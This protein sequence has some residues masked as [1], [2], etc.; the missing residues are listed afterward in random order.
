MVGATEKHSV[1]LRSTA[2]LRRGGLSSKLCEGRSMVPTLNEFGDVV[3]LENVDA[4]RAS[5]S[6][7]P[8]GGLEI[9]DVV[10]ARSPTEP[11][12]REAYVCKR[13]HAL[14][15]DPVPRDSRFDR[16]GASGT[17]AVGSYAGAGGAA[18]NVV[19]PDAVWLLGDNQRNSIDSRH[20][21]P[22]PL[23]LITGRVIFRV[24]PAD[25]A[26]PIVQRSPED[27]GRPGDAIEKVTK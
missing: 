10:M 17:G 15:G 8:Y 24:H 1:P 11:N 12:D 23:A 18:V 27:L 13:I 20:Y 19:P 26:G 16:S 9:G 22:V 5:S 7:K 6:S 3:L 21:G 4:S 25:E 14:P 2:A